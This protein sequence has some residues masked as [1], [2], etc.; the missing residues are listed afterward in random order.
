MKTR[1]WRKLD[2]IS[3]IGLLD[4][5]RREAEERD[6]DESW[7][8]L[9]EIQAILQERLTNV[10]YVNDKVEQLIQAVKELQGI[11]REFRSHTHGEDGIPR[12]SKPL[13]EPKVN[14]EI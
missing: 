2:T 12:I 1:E 3:L 8:N 14:A 10:D 13:Q 5:S 6:D 9:H 7:N 11:I 4:N